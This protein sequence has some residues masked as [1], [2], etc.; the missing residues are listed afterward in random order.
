MTY[1]GCVYILTNIFHTV[2]YTG[3]T[4]DLIVR[5]QQHLNKELP[6]S[7]ASKYNSV[8]LVYYKNFSRIEDAIAEEK[9]IKG[10]S[11]QKKMDL[12]GSINPKWEDLW[13][14]EVSK[15]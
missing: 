9:R 10:G 8:K 1:G 7:F 4:S 11:R 3:V 15:W 6:N 12:I 14:K 13:E 2:L 5:I